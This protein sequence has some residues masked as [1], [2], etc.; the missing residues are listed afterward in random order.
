MQSP[1]ILV[2]PRAVTRSHILTFSRRPGGRRVAGDVEVKVE[3]REQS[4]GFGRGCPA[5]RMRFGEFLDK[6]SDPATANGYYMSTQ[7]VADVEPGCPGIAGGLG[8]RLLE[9]GLAPARP[10]LLPT[11]IPQSVV[12]WMGA[13]APG[14]ETSSGL[15]HD[16]H[17]NLYVL[18]RGRKRF[19][20]FAPRDTELLQPRGEVLKVHRNGRINY[21]GSETAA[22]GRVESHH[23]H[24][25][26][27]PP[28]AAV[29]DQA[30]L[31]E[32]L[33]ALD[34]TELVA[35]VESLIERGLIQPPESGELEL[36]LDQLPAKAVTALDRLLFGQA[37]GSRRP[38]DEPLNF[39]TLPADP[40]T[41]L[42]VIPAPADALAADAA[43]ETVCEL[44]AGEMLYLPCGW[45][46]EV[47]SSS[48]DAGRASQ[49]SPPPQPHV[50]INWWFHPPDGSSFD[51]PYHSS[52]FRSWYQSAGLATHMNA[53]K[54]R[55]GR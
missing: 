28:S 52:F 41:G 5:R 2:R 49:P 23:A 21:V 45:W 44:S 3:C 17:D 19:R 15:H 30:A 42:A 20:L 39:S 43:T 27:N 53:W 29:V 31:A 14:R 32:R 51:A 7:D 12:V 26:N 55:S 8:L 1:Q 6:V 34:H 11:L 37:P 18:L 35:V 25:I 50:A 33:M 10:A 46:H 24:A 47:T 36:D 38:G 48:G 13:T 40:S 54:G 16:F 9:L 4:P 22:D